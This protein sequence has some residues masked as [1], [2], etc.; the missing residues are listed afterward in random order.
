MKGQSLVEFAISLV[1]LLIF[2]SGTVEFGISFFQFIQLRDA[3]QEGALFGSVCQNDATIEE[4]IRNASNA[5]LD[6]NDASVSVLID[7]PEGEGVAVRTRASYE[8][9]VFM[10]FA[11]VFAGKYIHISASVTDTILVEKTDCG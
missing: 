8:H 3:V 1:F 9:K 7:Y 2:L 4:R 10:P 6:L 5:P 11:S